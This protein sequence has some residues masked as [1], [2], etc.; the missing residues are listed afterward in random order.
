MAVVESIKIFYNPHLLTTFI[1]NC[2]CAFSSIFYA[3]IQITFDVN[4]SYIAVQNAR[5]YIF[6]TICFFLISGFLALHEKES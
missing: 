4:I 5:F 3:S 2:S 1:K 6:R